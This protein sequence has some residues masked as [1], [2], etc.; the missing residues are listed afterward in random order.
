MEGYD[1]DYARKETRITTAGLRTNLRPLSRPAG[2]PSGRE[3]LPPRSETR[4]VAEAA[5]AAPSE[6]LSVITSG[7]ARHAASPDCKCHRH[8]GRMEHSGSATGAFGSA[9]RASCSLMIASTMPHLLSAH[10]THA[11]RLQ[12]L[13][14]RNLFSGERPWRATSTK[15]GSTTIR[16]LENAT[17]PSGK[18]IPIR[19]APASHRQLGQRI[20]GSDMLRPK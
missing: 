6:L 14:N 2:L 3:D 19:L 9:V 7:Q 8:C 10:W 17:L 11:P 5:G 15:A 12:V 4:Y 13:L 20:A 18:M 16:S 1:S